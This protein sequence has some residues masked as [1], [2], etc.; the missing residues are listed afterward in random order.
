MN[1]HV[2]PHAGMEQSW[3]HP[4]AAVSFLKALRPGGPWTVS[5]IYPDARP[6]RLQGDVG[7]VPTR[8]FTDASQLRKW[9]ADRSGRANLYFTVAATSL[10]GKKPG[11]SDISAVEFAHV[12]IDDDEQGPIAGDAERKA[13][14]VAKL[15]NSTE[16]GPPTFLIDSGGGVQALWRLFGDNESLNHRADYEAINQA[17]IKSF[18]GDS[19]TWNLDR[20]LRLPGTVNIPDAKKLGRGRVPLPT[21]LIETTDRRYERWEFGAEPTQTKIRATQ[22]EIGQAVHTEDLDALAIRYNL[23]ART[24]TIVRNGR[25]KGKKPGDDS[26]SGWLFDAVCGLVRAGVPNEVTLGLITDPRWEIS[27]SVLDRD[28]AHRYATKQL[29]SAHNK[30][31]GEPERAFL[32]EDANMSDDEKG[33]W[34]RPLHYASGHKSN[35]TNGRLFLQARPGRMVTS[36]K[37]IFGLLPTGTWREIKEAALRSEIRTTNPTDTLDVN[38][39]GAMVTAVEDLTFTEAKPFEWIDEPASAPDPR[40]LVLFRNGLLDINSGKLLPLDGSYFATAVPD[41]DYD[42]L[43]DCPAWLHWLDERLDPSFHPT[44]QEWAGYVMVPD[45]TAH[46]FAT[47]TGPPRSGKSTSKNIIEQL[48]GTDHISRKQ[49]A[50]LGKEFGLQDAVDKRLIVVPDAKDVPGNQRGQALERLLAITG[51]DITGVPRKY[52]PAVSTKLLTRLLVLGNR[53]P[54]WIDESGAL[55]ARQLAIVFD[56]P[57]EGREDQNVENRLTAELPGIANWALEGLKRLRKNA[58]KFTVGDAGR[59]AVAEVRRSASP[60]LRFAEECLEVTGNPEDV[61]LIDEVFGVYEQWTYNEGL[62]GSRNKT[63]L[64]T[65]LET[66][67]HNVKQ[68]QTR[69]LPPPKDW[70]GG[71]YRPRVLQGVKRLIE[72]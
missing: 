3:S 49:L 16:P 8:S 40:N 28:D 46:R 38:N 6:A 50:D 39:V 45:T 9:I 27:S 31:N 32:D 48:V 68:T 71:E 58:Y 43:A 7:P 5:A 69:K 53:Q 23:P 10:I 59:A 17:L 42:E 20:L 15:M 36:D 47:F 26:R 64:M 33:A 18:G 62:H 41:F 66:S 19:G 12:D 54:Q 51:G 30:V 72:S 65:D 56:R 67:L 61:V 29:Q 55:A 60:A 63:D 37:V 34:P 13:A 22:V 70:K 25:L 44:L 52:L 1:E 14:V 24:L 35:A 2:A 11:A 21:K 57:F 4:D